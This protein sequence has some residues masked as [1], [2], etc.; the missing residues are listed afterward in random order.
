[1]SDYPLHGKVHRLDPALD[2]LLDPS[3][4]FEKLAHGLTWSEGPVWVPS[5]GAL[6]FSDIPRNTIFRWKEGEPMQTFL[7]PAGY[8]GVDF[9]SSEAGSNGLTLDGEGRFGRLQARRP[10]HL[11]ARAERRQVYAGYV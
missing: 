11:A 3:A 10:P 6:L 8:T 1:M 2:E 5:D 9:Y 4:R 7:Y